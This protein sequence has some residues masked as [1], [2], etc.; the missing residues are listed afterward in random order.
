[1]K[2]REG[3]KTW[4]VEREKKESRIVLRIMIDSGV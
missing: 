2:E 1:M 4:L 3:E